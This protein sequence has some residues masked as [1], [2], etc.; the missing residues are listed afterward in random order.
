MP[1]ERIS[2][3]LLSHWIFMK[4]V[5]NKSIFPIPF[6]IIIFHVDIY[7]LRVIKEKQSNEKSCKLESGLGVGLRKKDEH[8]DNTK[9]LI[10]FSRWTMERI[11]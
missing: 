8:D 6:I 7:Y 3:E 4:S 1:N 9:H 2:F 5:K 11:K 10:S